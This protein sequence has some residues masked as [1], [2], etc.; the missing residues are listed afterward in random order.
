[1]G[2]L[3]EFN[4]VVKLNEFFWL[5]DFDGVLIIILMFIIISVYNEI[6]IWKKNVFFVFYGWIG[7]DFIDELIF[8]INDW[9]N[10]IDF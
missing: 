5:F 9:N 1:M 4:F 6:V 8:C 10:G 2:W 7:K 3:F